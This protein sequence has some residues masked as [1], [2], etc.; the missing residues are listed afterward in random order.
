MTARSFSTLLLFLF[1]NRL[2][3]AQ[4]WICTR[5][6]DFDFGKIRRLESG[7]HGH[8]YALDEQMRLGMIR[9]DTVKDRGKI[10]IQPAL[11]AAIPLQLW[12]GHEKELRTF[13]FSSASEDGRQLALALQ[14]RKIIGENPNG[15]PLTEAIRHEIL[16]L[17]FAEKR[18]VFRSPTGIKPVSA[19]FGQSLRFT[20]TDGKDLQVMVWDGEGEKARS[21][22][23]PE[24]K[25]ISPHLRLGSHLSLNNREF[26]TGD[27]AVITDD[28]HRIS[29]RLS[30][31][32]L[33]ISKDEKEVRK[34]SLPENSDVEIFRFREYHLLTILPADS[35]F[36]LNPRNGE[37][38]ALP[39]PEGKIHHQSCLMDGN[40]LTGFSGN[41]FSLLSL[42]NGKKQRSLPVKSSS[43]WFPGL[44]LPAVSGK[45]RIVCWK[46]SGRQF[47]YNLRSRQLSMEQAGIDSSHDSFPLMHSKKFRI[48]TTRF[49]GMEDSSR[50]ASGNFSP[51]MYL[52]G[53][54]IGAYQGNKPENFMALDVHD[55]IEKAFISYHQ[56]SITALSPAGKPLW[57]SHC[58][59]PVLGLKADE[60]GQTLCAITSLGTVEFLHSKTGRKYLSLAF[61]SSGKE[62]ILWTPSGYYDASAGGENLLAWM[63]PSEETAFP[64]LFSVAAFSKEFRKPEIVDAAMLC[65]DEEEALRRLKFTGG[66]NATKRRLLSLPADISLEFPGD[67]ISFSATEWKL[68]Y[69]TAPG[70]LP[71]K[72]IQ[73]ILNGKALPDY[74]P[75][76]KET[77]PLH[78][79]QENSSLELIPFSAAGE[80]T[81]IRCRLQWN[82]PH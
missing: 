2:L 77:I 6:S 78:L 18:I 55:K 22:F 7:P 61:D 74:L 31:A 3:Q 20:A 16:V 52:N 62:W 11:Q 19:F 51:G 47:R 33:T 50:A 44:P 8:V 82:P 38:K 59:A 29:L 5:E 34:F 81:R 13:S 53:V 21:L 15:S 43:G 45:D 35:F 40:I 69:F 28:I 36:L 80:G 76:G 10:S 32:G 41:S 64:G 75:D 54:R 63:P 65:H 79:P 57:T 60:D 9:F 14:S 72:K 4:E 12:P 23:R 17:D 42:E 68:P 1:C 25:N 39:V 27:G 37:L 67:R 70:R 26:G 48:S 66:E 73:L 58:S 56:P 46:K 30:A 71:L 49:D 24:Q